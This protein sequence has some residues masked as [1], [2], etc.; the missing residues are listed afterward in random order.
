MVY[1]KLHKNNIIA[2]RIQTI[3]KRVC[4]LL[5]F[6]KERF[7]DTI[8][9]HNIGLEVLHLP[10]FVQQDPGRDFFTFMMTGVTVRTLEL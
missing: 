3:N 8:Q 7:V 10:V 2:H 5:F 4:N 1:A 6:N 9:R